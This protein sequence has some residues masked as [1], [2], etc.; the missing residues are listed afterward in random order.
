MDF[1]GC[2]VISI[3]GHISCEEKYKK[4]MRASCLKSA[5]GAFPFLLSCVSIC[6]EF[7]LL[8]NDTWDT[9]CVSEEPQKPSLLPLYAD[10]PHIYI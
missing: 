10:V 8:F 5:K 3:G 2:N 9:C 4:K 6:H 7:Y 1:W